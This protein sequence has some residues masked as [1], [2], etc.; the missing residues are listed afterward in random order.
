MSLRW[1]ENRGV[2]E[3]LVL[4]MGLGLVVVAWV[5]AQG[6]GVG[7]PAEAGEGPGVAEAGGPAQPA[8]VAALPP[9]EELLPNTTA[10]VVIVPDTQN[11]E[12]HWNQTQLGRLAA[13]PVMKP[14]AEDL[15]RQFESR[16]TTLRQRLGMSLDDLKQ[17]QGRGLAV[18]FTRPKDAPVAQVV[19]LDVRGREQAA[20][21]LLQKAAQQQ[22]ARGAK[23]REELTDGVTVT[24]FDLPPAPQPGG[25]QRVAYFLHQGLLCGADSFEAVE[26][27]LHRWSQGG[28]DNLAAVSGFQAV[29]RR[30][31]QDAGQT[32]RPQARWFIH[33]LSY[34]EV[35]RALTPEEKR[36]KGR[37][38]GEL[39]GNQGLEAVQ[40][41]G[42]FVD[43]AA[44]GFERIHRTALYAPP[45]YEKA[46][47]MVALPNGVL[48]PPPAWV[49]RDVASYATFYV[50]LVKAFDNFGPLFD[51]LY[52]QGEEGV[53]EDVLEG[54][55]T[56]PNGPQIDLRAE[57]IV[58]LGPRVIMLSDYSLPITPTSE[59]LLFAVEAKDPQAVAAAVAK[60]M[61]TDQSVRRRE[62]GGH[63]IWE[64]VEPPPVSVPAVDVRGPSSLP[65][66]EP[67]RGERKPQPRKKQ[68]MPRAAVTVAQGYLIVASHIEFLVEV[69]QPREQREMLA[70]DLDYRVVAG[71]LQEFGLGECCGLRFARTDEENHV[72]YELVRQ[73]K[74]P[75]AESLIG[76]GLNRLFGAADV[77][78]TRESKLDGS[79]LPKFDVV[80]RFLGPAGLLMR[81]EPDG[82]F[83]KGVV[84]AK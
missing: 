20:N 25:P 43:F 56:D 54:L 30:C 22:L 18:A 75:E 68:L 73:N 39:M 4:R 33:P 78:T 79:K 35:V 63:V 5:L 26:D 36:R 13:D 76:W 48:P 41:I 38:I 27:V 37:S 80:R 70:N 50:D 65:F 32:A 60:T 45:P 29:M 6:A 12:Q 44:E 49:P 52:G 3:S 51:D 83:I 8:G 34:A 57:L 10:A 72:T 40:G 71:K 62:L 31:R 47:N 67:R 58:H 55:R 21:A 7:G 84:L 15:Q 17:L 53:W 9:P 74:L 66:V 14:F 69:L 1:S 46:M 19:L 61:R 82:W 23:R 2:R 81:S 24:V 28:K 77:G 59:R 16:W 11:L 42:G 64:T